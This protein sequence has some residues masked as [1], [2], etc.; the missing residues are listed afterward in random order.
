M[1]P[2]DESI[3]TIVGPNGS[4]KTTLLDAMRTVLALNTSRKRSYPT[5]VQHSNR[6]YAWLRA[7]V[8]NQRDHRGRR[9]F[10]PLT[11]DQVTLACRVMR[12]S[13]E[14]Q[15]ETFEASR[16]LLNQTHA[17]GSSAKLRPQKTHG[18]RGPVQHKPV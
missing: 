10:F 1:L 2:L 16:N 13:G 11:T 14:W 18:E 17:P 15:A 8:T 9:P 12:R 7:V 6:P 5:Y 4:G 3:I